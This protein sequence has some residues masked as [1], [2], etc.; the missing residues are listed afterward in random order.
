MSTV[1]KIKIQNQKKVKKGHKVEISL[2]KIKQCLN[3]KKQVKDNT[4]HK[5]MKLNISEFML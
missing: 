3:N 4:K 1:K 2:D 5:K